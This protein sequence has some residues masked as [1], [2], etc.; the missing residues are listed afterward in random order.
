MYCA[1]CFGLQCLC[2]DAKYSYLI[3]LYVFLRPSHAQD[4][5]E[6]VYNIDQDDED[7]DGVGDKC[8][9]CIFAPN[10]DQRNDD[11]DTTGN[12][13][14]EDDDNDG[15]C[16][17]TLPE[18]SSS[19]IVFCYSFKDIPCIHTCFRGGLH[20]TAMIT[21]MMIYMCLCKEWPIVRDTDSKHYLFLYVDYEKSICTASHVNF[22]SL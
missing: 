5:C 2:S 17:Y 1:Y 18:P 4:N 21:C 11:G 15:K 8:D 14:D 10:K 12:A 9:N 20:M 6:D 3:F 7:G 16:K 22:L 13:C 19:S